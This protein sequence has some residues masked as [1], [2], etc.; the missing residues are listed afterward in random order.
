MWL[1]CVKV[2]MHTKDLEQGVGRCVGILN[3]NFKFL[4]I[5]EAEGSNIETGCLC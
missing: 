3:L 5:G 4:R 2:D 1:T